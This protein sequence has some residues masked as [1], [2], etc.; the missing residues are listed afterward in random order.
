MKQQ[1]IVMSLGDNVATALEN[2]KTNDSVEVRR[3]VELKTYTLR[4]D[5]LFGHKFATEAILKGARVIKYGQ[6]MGAATQ[7]IQE[8]AHAHVHNVESLRGRGDK[9]YT[10]E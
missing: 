7:D 8:G 6:V 4:Q 2:L 10:A 1:T 5:I 3:G 9:R